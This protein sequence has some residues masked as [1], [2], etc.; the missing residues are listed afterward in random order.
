MRKGV[1]DNTKTTPK[2]DS[3]LIYYTPF[4]LPPCLGPENRINMEPDYCDVAISLSVI[5]FRSDR[6]LPGGGGAICEKT[7]FFLIQGICYLYL[8][9]E[10]AQ[11]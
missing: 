8:Y 5:D 2:I 10:M 7:I 9:P 3:P 1:P 4:F 11:I 6:T